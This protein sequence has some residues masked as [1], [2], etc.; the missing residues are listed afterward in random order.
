[1]SLCNLFRKQL[2]HVQGRVA[3]FEK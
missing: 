1:M 2:Y 3:A